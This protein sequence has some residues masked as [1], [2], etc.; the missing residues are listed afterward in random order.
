VVF[1]FIKKNHVCV[2]C[3]LEQDLIETFIGENVKNEEDYENY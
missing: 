2:K 3:N 1:D